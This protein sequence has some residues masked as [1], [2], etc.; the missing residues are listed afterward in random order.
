VD[1]ELHYKVK[2]NKIFLQMSIMGNLILEERRSQMNRRRKYLFVWVAMA[3]G[4]TLWFGTDVYAQGGGPCSGDVA[5]FCKDVQRGGGR[6]AKCLVEHEKELSPPCKQHIAEMKKRLK[7][8]A[9]ACHDDA[10]KFCKDV[11]QGEGRILQ[12]LMEHQNDLSP[13]CRE[14]IG[15]P[16]KEQ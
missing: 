12:C 8:T 2:I 1:W 5:K 10:L 9:Q 15:L 4:V 6:I 7:E 3:F 16:R 14:R 11:K 13:E